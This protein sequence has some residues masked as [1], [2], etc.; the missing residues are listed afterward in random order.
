M[1][2]EKAS[3]VHDKILDAAEKHVLDHGASSLT[4]EAVA[5]AAEVSKGGLLYHFPSKD[6]LIKGLVK[7]VYEQWMICL[8][9]AFAKEKPGKGHMARVLYRD[10]FDPQIPLDSPQWKRH[11]QLVAAL[12][13]AVSHN[14]NLILCCKASYQNFLNEFEKDELPLGNSLVMM[15]VYDA[16]WWSTVFGTYTLNE[17]QKAALQKTLGNLLE[18]QNEENL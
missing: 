10:T 2:P 1:P 16:M 5:K 17:S 13:A 15:C 9:A 11:Q 14:P 7:R 18:I 6:E 3:P 12:A 8:Q 4:L